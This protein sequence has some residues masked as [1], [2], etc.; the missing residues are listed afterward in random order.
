MAII[1]SIENT[2][3]SP[4]VLATDEIWQT[5]FGSVFLTTSASPSAND[6]ISLTEGQAVHVRAGLSV[7]VRKEGG[8]AARIAHEAV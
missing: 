5:R 8:T 6:G 3:S 4:V 1:D 2:W 7:R